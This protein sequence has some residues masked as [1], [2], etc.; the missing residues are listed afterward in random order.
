MRIDLRPAARASGLRSKALIAA[1]GVALGVALTLWS[2]PAPES[3]DSAR[4]LV[5]DLRYLACCQPFAKTEGEHL[6][7]FERKMPDRHPEPIAGHVL[8]GCL[9]WA[10]L[11]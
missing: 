6:L 9:C 2:R 5:H 3:L 4:C 1:G 11:A 8:L 7:L 10:V